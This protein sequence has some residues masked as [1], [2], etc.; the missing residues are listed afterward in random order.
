LWVAVAG[1][2]SAF[3]LTL[4]FGPGAYWEWRK[5]TAQLPAER[6]KASADIRDRMR[7]LLGEIISFKVS[8][9]TLK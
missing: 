4:L 5:T 3:I 1:T 9:F 6:T 7:V 8:H 2:V